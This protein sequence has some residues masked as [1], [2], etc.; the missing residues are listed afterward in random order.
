MVE[1]GVLKFGPIHL[2]YDEIA[3]ELLIP[4]IQGLSK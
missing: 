1:S 2:E 4:N 3:Y